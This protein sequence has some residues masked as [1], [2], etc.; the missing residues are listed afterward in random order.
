MSEL[1]LFTLIGGSVSV[2][3][4]ELT[5][6]LRLKKLLTRMNEHSEPLTLPNGLWVIAIV[7]AV[8]LGVC[9][10]AL[11]N[12]SMPTA[13]QVLAGLFI[14]GMIIGWVAGFMKWRSAAALEGEAREQAVTRLPLATIDLSISFAL[15]LLVCTLGVAA[16]EAAG[17]WNTAPL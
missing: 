1:Q 11:S 14:A 16:G 15:A 2:A 13:Y 17:L 4:L 9:V 8:W 12:W 7:E 5:Q 10:H 6:A 3:V